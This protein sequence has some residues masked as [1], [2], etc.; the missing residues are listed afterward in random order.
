MPTSLPAF[1]AKFS[2]DCADLGAERGLDLVEEASA[3]GAFLAGFQLAE[4]LEQGAL[5]AGQPGRRLDRDLDDHVAAPAPLQDRHPRSALAQLLARLYAGGDFQIEGFAVQA[6]YLD[7]PT[8]RRRREADRYPCRQRRAFALEDRMLL[9]VNEYV[10]VAGRRAVRPGFTLAGE[11]DAGAGV[12]TG[13]NVE[14]DLLRDV[15]ATF[16][17]AVPTGRSDDFAATVAVGAWP[18]DYE[19]TLLGTHLALT[20]AQIAGASVS[21]RRRAGTL[22][23]VAGLADFDLDLFG[24]AVKGILE[25]NLKIVAQ[26]GAAPG[27][28]AAAG[29]AAAEDRLENIADIAEIL[30]SAT[31]TAA[32]LLKGSMAE[33]VV[34]RRVLRVFEAIKG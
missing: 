3:F 7:R 4:F 25:F 15:D 19:E 6:R 18:L 27:L 16:T 34:G 1:A 26:I 8:Q 24:L 28:L 12:D 10:E 29:K 5:F 32:A 11:A 17:P 33:A 20:R 23:R 31:P 30:R 9:H 2:N 13:R 22:A 14:I 21:A